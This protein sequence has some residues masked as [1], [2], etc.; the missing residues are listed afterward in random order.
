M[1]LKN[2]Q[3]VQVLECI[4]CWLGWRSTVRLITRCSSLQAHIVFKGLGSY[5]ALNCSQELTGREKILF[6]Q[7]MLD[8]L[9]P[10]KVLAELLL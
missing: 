4:I 10:E 8:N 6:P 7:G 3:C 2:R 9:Y 1:D 5:I